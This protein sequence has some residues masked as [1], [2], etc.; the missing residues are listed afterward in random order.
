MAAV[1]LDACGRE[2]PPLDRLRGAAETAADGEVPTPTPL[3]RAHRVL[4][5]ADYRG[6]A[7]SLS[8]CLCFYL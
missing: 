1:S 4:A 3:I 7:V 2:C 6:V 8:L 5:Q